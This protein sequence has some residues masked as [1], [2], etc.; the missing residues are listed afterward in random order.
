M[1]KMDEKAFEDLIWNDLEK[2]NGYEKDQWPLNSKEESDFKEYAIDTERLF[3]FLNLNQKEKLQELHLDQGIEKKKFL[4]YLDKEIEKKGILRV[5]NNPFKYK[6]LELDLYYPVP[7]KG[8]ST[9]EALYKQNI[10][11]VVRQVHFS[12]KR[13]L[14]RNATKFQTPSFDLGLFV[15]GFIVA[16]IEI[17]NSITGQTVDNAEKQYKLRDKDEK[18]FAFKFCAVHFALDDHNVEFCTDLSKEHPFFMP[19]N[20]GYN[21]S[22]GNPPNPN[23]M[24]TDYFWKDIFTKIGFSEI[25]EK[26]ACVVEEEEEDDNG[27]I[28]KKEKQ[29]FPRYHQLK[30]VGNL[31]KEVDAD[32][33][34]KKY[35]IQ[36]S[37][38]S[39][40]SNTIAWLAY[41][42]VDLQKDSKPLFDS[43]IVVTDRRNL[44]KQIRNTIKGFNINDS[45]VGWATHTTE[46]GKHY[47][48]SN[49]LGK[50]IRDGKKIIITTVH[51]F[52]FIHEDMD[53]GENKDKRFAV[54]IDEAHSSQNG[55]LAIEMN[56]KLSG[57]ELDPEH[58]DT[59]TLINKLIKSRKMAKNVSFFAFTATP[60]EKTL[61]TFG[62]TVRDAEGNI[63]YKTP[64]VYS[65]KQAIDEGFILDVL[66]FYTPVDVFYK[67]VKTTDDDPSVKKGKAQQKLRAIVEKSPE[68]IETKAK[69]IVEQFT[70]KTCKE[71]KGQARAMV[72]TSRIERAVDYYVAINKFLEEQNS[73]Y[74]TIIAFSGSTKYNGEQYTEEKFNG[75]PSNE[76]EK[77]FKKD[78]YRILIVADKFQTGFDEPLL[79]SIFVDKPLAGIDA[80]Q[81]LSRLNRCY[82]N[83]RTTF[84]LD[85]ANKAADIK[86]S[87]NPFYLSTVLT[88]ESDVN[89]LNEC[90]DIF[91]KF[92][93]F[94]TDDVE[95]FVDLYLH[96]ASREELDPILDQCRM[97]FMQIP[98]LDDKFDFKKACKTFVT[99]YTYLSSI[100]PYGKA[101]WEKLNIF[102]FKLLGKLPRLT[103]DDD[104][105][106]PIEEITDLDYYI[107]KKNEL[108]AI[109]L[110]DK[111]GELTPFNP[112]AT[113]SQIEE[114]YE[115]LSKV[116][117]AFNRLLK[118]LPEEQKPEIKAYIEKLP[119]IVSADE[120]YRNAMANNNAQTAFKECENA[121]FA[122]IN[123]LSPQDIA[124]FNLYCAIHNEKSDDFKNLL[125]DYV[126][127]M[128]YNKK[129][130]S[131]ILSV[132]ETKS[133]Y[134]MKPNFG[135]LKVA[136]TPKDPYNAK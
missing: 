78:P 120:T 79:H 26:F 46:G 76:I 94:S 8:N 63:I 44:D 24:Q 15:N 11:A 97:N 13:N 36:H 56:K 112:S 118:N 57:V 114:E 135:E 16:T 128:T 54:L 73:P 34:G 121:L 3:R 6:H 19:F 95:K 110:D 90:C 101:D 45:I 104:D 133:E 70:T 136:Q 132:N 72:I 74:K 59:Q 93:V 125:L 131:K 88:G 126:F 1:T 106:T 80:V 107:P 33:C 32:G 22:K 100:L 134:K 85:F 102:L 7:T 64:Y 38:G 84:I 47:S 30:T 117:D 5:L 108:Q 71:I 62:R 49:Y 103:S 23:G 48:G 113:S 77:K 67:I 89:K 123:Q 17:K 41:Q 25:I 115:K 51:K 20:K 4:E 130:D 21:N 29:I 58:E 14:D 92:P 42:L 39:G 35:L 124:K 65:M 87:F 50:L 2:L 31:I 98:E 68:A 82:P 9:A 55:E 37:A 52:S 53:L 116:L 40:K 119:E 99:F 12:K 109:L 105:D 60:S 43:V 111:N 91:D 69:I 127:Q 96:D 28:I 83:K 81:T 61:E 129:Q 27:K 122:F 86:K 10:F 75:F 66:K 18:V